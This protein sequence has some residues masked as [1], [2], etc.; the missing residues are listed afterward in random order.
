[1]K[2]KPLVNSLVIFK[3]GGCGRPRL[4]VVNRPFSTQTP[5]SYLRRALSR[6]AATCRGSSVPAKR[7]MALPRLPRGAERR[8]AEPP[9]GDVRNSPGNVSNSSPA[10]RSIRSNSTAGPKP[11]S[12]IPVATAWSGCE[13]SRDSARCVPSRWRPDTRPAHG[14]GR[15]GPACE[16]RAK[17]APAPACKPH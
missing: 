13:V 5:I 4:N 12:R 2:I 6:V 14:R 11:C 1:M 8:V 3:I 7:R 10:L 17:T 16:R 9:A 15:S